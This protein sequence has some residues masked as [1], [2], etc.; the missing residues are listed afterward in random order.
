MA[1]VLL[2]GSQLAW[3]LCYIALE[4]DYHLRRRSCC[5]SIPAVTS[6][7]VTIRCSAAVTLAPLTPLIMQLEPSSSRLS[8]ISA[9]LTRHSG[10]HSTCSALSAQ[11][12]NCF[13]SVSASPPTTSRYFIVPHRKTSYEPVSLQSVSSPS[14][15]LILTR[16]GTCLRAQ[17]E[18]PRRLG[19]VAE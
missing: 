1:Y 15:V 4:Q 19:M 9:H 3:L 5:T 6:L 10:D 17:D 11:P 2:Y 16:S 7:E 13:S 8:P 18:Q 14:I 12:S